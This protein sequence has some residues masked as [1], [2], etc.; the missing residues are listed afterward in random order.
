MAASKL[1]IECVRG[2]TAG[3]VALNISQ[4]VR[5]FSILPLSLDLG[6]VGILELLTRAEGD[7]LLP[8]LDEVFFILFS[9]LLHAIKHLLLL[10]LTIEA[11]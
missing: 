10:L 7:L 5:L 3:A 2:E 6:R 4:F 11:S 9:F 1:R 8:V